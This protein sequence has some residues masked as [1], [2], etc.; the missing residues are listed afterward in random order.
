[1]IVVADSSPLIIL[2]KLNCFDILNRLYPRLHISAEV[3]S[4]VVVAGTG[5]PGAQQVAASAW[6]EVT[7]IQNR[8]A[9]LAA[10]TKSSLGVGELST[11][12]LSKEIHADAVILDDFKARKLAK[13]EGLQVRGTVGVLENLYRRCHLAD[14]RAAFQQLLVHEVYIDRRLL[15]RRLHAL[16]L[17]PL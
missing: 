16:G 10:Q 5:L 7:P 3:Y 14:L 4:E 17:P 11:I 12:V 13:D 6:I 2:A 1:V 9:L 8:A 15:N